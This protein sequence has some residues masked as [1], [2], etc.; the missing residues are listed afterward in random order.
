MLS[1]RFLASLVVVA[2]FSGC[3]TL[4]PPPYS[5]DYQALDQLKK[6]A[7]EKVAVG[8]FQPRNADAPVNKISL[9]AAN[10]AGPKGTFAQY[11]EDAMIQ[12]LK[13]I[14]VFDVGAETRIEATL[15]KN[16]IDVSGLSTGTGRIDVELTITRNGASTLKK[17]YSA[18]TK[19][20]SSFMGGVAIPKGQSEYP[21]L[22]RVLLSKVYADPEFIKALKK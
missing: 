18:E 10:L 9:R 20:E 3:S 11:L 5:P 8:T 6:Q 1:I 21:N 22:V 4:V 13:E 2:A 12:D 15:L 16:D 7:L 14:G 17:T 19:F